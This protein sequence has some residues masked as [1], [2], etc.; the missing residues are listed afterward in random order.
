MLF[1]SGDDTRFLISI[2]S[3]PQWPFFYWKTVKPSGQIQPE[4]LTA[5]TIEHDMTVASAC[6]FQAVR[7]TTLL[8]INNIHQ[9]K[10][11]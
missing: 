4:W 6:V 8:S 9:S 1:S 10:W 5:K 2:S 11:F 3:H 7:E